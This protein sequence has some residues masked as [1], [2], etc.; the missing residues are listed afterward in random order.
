MDGF[1]LA[2]QADERDFYAVQSDYLFHQDWAWF[3]LPT[4]RITPAEDD[5]K[6]QARI[7][8]VNGSNMTKWV[9]KNQYNVVMEVEKEVV[10]HDLLLSDRVDAYVSNLRAGLELLRMKGVPSGDIRFEVFRIKPLSVYFTK[11][12]LKERPRFLYTFN[13]ALIP[14]RVSES[15]NKSS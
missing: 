14:C 7:A 5:F 13:E 4:A 3:Y 8:G 6:K 15:P 1:F 9:A 12:F 10:L 2:S 11:S